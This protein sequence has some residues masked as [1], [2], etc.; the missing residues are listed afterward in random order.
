MAK[1]TGSVMKILMVDDDELLRAT[2]PLMLRVF[3]HQVDTVDGGRAA[4]DYLSRQVLP[5]LV[6]L[7]MN[8][9]DMTGAETLRHIRSREKGLPVL[10]ATGFVDS[11]VESLVQTDPYTMVIAKPFSLAEI[12]EKIISM[13]VMGTG[14]GQSPLPGPFAQNDEAKLILDR[15]DPVLFTSA[16]LAEEGPSMPEQSGKEEPLNILLIEDN[17]IDA[18]LIEGLLKKRGLSFLLRRIEAPGELDEALAGGKIDIVISDFRLPGWDGMLALRRVRSFDPELPFLL[19]SGEVG[20]ELVVDEMVA[21]ANDFFCKDRLLRLAA[22]IEREARD[23]MARRKIRELRAEWQLL[24]QAVQHSTDWV[25][26]TDL[27][28]TIVYVNP[29][30]ELV[31]GYSATELLGKNQRLLKSGRHDAV[32]YQGMWDQLLKGQ[33]WRGLVT[34]RRK[35]GTMWDSQVLITPV[36][37]EHG[38]LTG[39]A[40][41]G[42]IEFH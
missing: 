29:A 8:M 33:T 20:E 11:E 41:S 21:G 2:V 35:D 34:N 10:L 40:G 6:I 30:T 1:P 36:R 39:Y 37:N 26:L 12:N 19:V 24:H 18:L 28:G 7:D 32:F 23:R 15:Q 5:D 13:E 27:K 31:T 17:S 4:L 25:I 16:L 42:R 38:T 3:G 14:M 22:A 9:P